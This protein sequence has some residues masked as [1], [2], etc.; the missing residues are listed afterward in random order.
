[1]NSIYERNIEIE[2]HPIVEIKTVLMWPVKISDYIT[3]YL[4]LFQHGV[5][6]A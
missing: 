4:N 1:M 6:K 5:S 3:K 2:N